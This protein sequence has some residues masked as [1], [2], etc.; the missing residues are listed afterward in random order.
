MSEQGIESLI[1][2]FGKL[3][4]VV[5]GD[6][7]LD[8][9]IW[10]NV[11]RISPEAPV[12]VVEVTRESVYPGGAANVA[13]NIT[14]FGSKTELIGL[15][16]ADSEGEVLAGALKENNIGIEHLLVEESFS[17]ITKTRV[18]AQHQQ[19]VRIDR[20]R[21]QALTDEAR[22]QVLNQLRDVVG[23]VDGIIIE[24]YGKGLIDDEL[25]REVVDIASAGNV[26]V[27]VDPNPKNPID[28][29]GV[30]TVKPNRSEAFH[31]AGMADRGGHL[32]PLEDDDLLEVGSRLM[33]RWES[34][35]VL[36][37][38]GEQGMILF[39]DGG[40]PYH[41]PTRAREVFDVSGAGDT[42]IAVFTMALCA[43]ADALTAADLSNR[44]SGVVVGKLGT[45]E[46]TKEDLLKAVA[47]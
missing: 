13:R 44:A 43:G 46:I 20:E 31:E 26:I 36:I 47:S 29:K 4:L 40:E 15:V 25:V 5:I 8:R 6:V 35:Y 45:A 27:T 10:G 1:E 38:L 23:E 28:W 16:G 24:D 41:I 18:V 39:S 21:K 37:T 17:T 33:K 19:V 7:M 3:R 22:A 2:S 34:Q 11:T 14:P 30:S 9:F 12:P 42:A 32:P